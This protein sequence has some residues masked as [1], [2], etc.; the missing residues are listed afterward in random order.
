MKRKALL[1][2]LFLIGYI[3]VSFAQE[4]NSAFSIQHSGYHKATPRRE[5]RHL[6]THDG[7]LIEE[8][9]PMLRAS[10]EYIMT[11]FP[12][13]GV[14]KAPV[15]LAAFSDVP[16][17]ADSVIIKT[18]LS[19]RYNA[20]NYSED[21]NF[22]EYSKVYGREIA[23]QVDIP[24][25]ARDYFRDQS[26]GQFVPQFDV[27]GPV[28][29]SKERA[30]Y[31]GN[32]NS[33][34]DKNARSMILEACQK[35]Y[36]QGLTDFTDY[37]NDGDGEVDIVYVVYAGYD[38]AQSYIEEC[39]WAHAYNI[40]LTLDNGMRVNRYACSGELVID[41]PVVAGI[42]TF[43]HEFSHILGLPDFYNTQNTSSTKLTM[44]YWSVMDYG[45]YTAEGF[46]PCAYTAFE[47]YSLGWLPMHTLD[48]PDTMS[49]G[50]TD[51]ERKG[52]RIFTKDLDNVDF[53]TASDTSSFYLIE[54]IRNEGWNKYAFAEG[55]L[56]SQ[57]T[58]NA[59][60]WQDNKVN[61]GSAHRHY[62][63]PANN[64]WSINESEG[65]N[66]RKH[67]YGSVNKE[68]TPTSTPASITQFGVTMNKPLTDIS[69]NTQTGKTTFHF[70]GGN[71]VDK[72]DETKE[73]NSGISIY[74][75]L[76][77]RPI[78]N[79]SRGIYIQNGKKVMIK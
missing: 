50:T 70:R 47:R 10:G 74:Y 54:T 1:T 76:L 75:D 41:L 62:I 55:L 66:P 69:Y 38:E 79:P 44:D 15:I 40:S 34:N 17:S 6:I 8:S 73:L 21:V 64:S 78:E 46:V 20:D 24:G 51:E 27:I 71:M 7:S 3:A 77:G 36:Q 11:K 14:V 31:G 59:K 68:F 58:Y 48:A 43:V 52:Y 33:G 65:Y 16:F 30:Y 22:K 57:V 28:T 29:L 18:L 56:I 67:L 32:N 13:M 42:G 4:H 35:A 37:D 39:I 26:F 5:I 2:S 49:I 60:A 53:I 63:V 61:A 72:V 25:S 23:V 45:N 19:K 12:T 9:N